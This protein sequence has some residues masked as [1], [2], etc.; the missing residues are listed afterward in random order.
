MAR[1]SWIKQLNVLTITL[2]CRVST[3]SENIVYMRLSLFLRE[4]L[5][6]FLLY[7]TSRTYIHILMGHQFK[8]DVSLS[9]SVSALF[10]SL[11]RLK[12]KKKL[13]VLFGHVD[14]FQ[15]S[16]CVYIVML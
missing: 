16:T 5:K 10:N 14:R 11:H 6:I 2:N 1:I 12:L 7:F 4:A 13:N 3:V 15:G 9:M 8:M